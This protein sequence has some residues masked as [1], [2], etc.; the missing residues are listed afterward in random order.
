M[1]PKPITVSISETKAALSRL[2][3]AAIKG[4]RV[5]ISR[6]GVPVV[7]LVALERRSG[8]RPGT[9]PELKVGPEFFVPLS[10]QELGLPPEDKA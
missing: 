5:I 2:I 10:D 4:Q 9:H 1:K 8:R 3:E 7:E 6:K